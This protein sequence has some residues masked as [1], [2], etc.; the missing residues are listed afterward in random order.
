MPHV[1]L[2]RCRDPFGGMTSFEREDGAMS[3]TREHG[4]D[5]QP[6]ARHPQRRSRVSLFRPA[7]GLLIATVV[8]LSAGC[9]DAPKTAERPPELVK[10]APVV[11]RDV[12]IYA[13]W[14]GTTVG[15]VTAQIRARVAGYLLSQKY[16]EG[17]V[18]KAGDLLF[19]IDP[20]PYQIALSQARAQLKTAESQLE[21]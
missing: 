20:R 16:R 14:V 17:T 4:S 7:A 1:P 10:V 19:E 3:V 6:A 13:E 15:Y 5:W 9:K 11:Q 12:P 18:V 8:G 2:G 21:Q